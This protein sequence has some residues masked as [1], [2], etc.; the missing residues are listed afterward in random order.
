MKALADICEQDLRYS[1]RVVTEFTTPEHPFLLPQAAL[2]PWTKEHHYE[3]VRKLAL[4]SYVPEVIRTQFDV[5]LNTAIYALFCWELWD[6]AAHKAVD[7]FELALREAMKSNTK[8][9]LAAIIDQAASRDILTEQEKIAG[10]LLR[11]WRNELSHAYTG[12]LG[13]QAH[14]LIEGCRTLITNVSNRAGSVRTSQKSGHAEQAY[15]LSLSG[16]SLHILNELSSALGN[17]GDAV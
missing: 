14:I 12:T 13:I 15:S 9:R 17:L 11:K 7:C 6:V 8:D 2:V 4:S 16:Y 3:I 5:A 10:H 1:S